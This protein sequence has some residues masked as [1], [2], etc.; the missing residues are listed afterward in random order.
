MTGLTLPKGLGTRH[1]AAAAITEVT[2]ALAVVVSQSN[3]TVRLFQNGEVILRIAPMRHAR[4]MKWQDAETEPALPSLAPTEN[5]TKTETRT[6]IRDR[7]KEKPAL[8]EGCR[9]AASGS[10][11]DFLNT[12]AQVLSMPVVF[13]ASGR[14]ALPLHVR[15]A[16]GRSPPFLSLAYPAARP[17]DDP[18]RDERRRGLVLV[19]DGV[20]GL[21]LC[22]TALRYVLGAEGLPYAVPR[23]SLGAR[24]R[25]LVRRPDERDQPRRQG[26][27]AGRRGAA[28]SAPASR[29]I[30][31]SWS[32]SRG[33]RA[34]WSRR[35]SSSTKTR[36]SRA[37]L[38]APALSPGYDL[39]AA[40]RAVRRE[41]VVFWSP[42]DVI[43]LGAGTR[44]FGTVDRVKTVGAG[45][46]GFRRPPRPTRRRGRQRRRRRQYAKLRQVRW[47]PRMA[48]TGYLGGHVGPDSPVFLRKYVVPLLRA[49]P[50]G[51][52]LN[53]GPGSSRS[54]RGPISIWPGSVGRREG[55][56]AGL[57]ASSRRDETGR[58]R[59]EV[60][61]VLKDRA[62]LIVTRRTSSVRNAAQ[63]GRQRP[64][65]GP[66]SGRLARSR[67]TVTARGPRPRT[68]IGALENWLP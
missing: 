68:A 66:R 30:R 11:P 52:V 61:Q 15:P 10:I 1:W 12:I 47:A 6:R 48:A 43:V 57:R 63:A 33:A 9:V 49:G 25:P 50:D 5:G 13:Q 60:L 64:A 35:S 2:K 36:S 22:G 56:L 67:E 26:R 46:V 24:L 7:D 39:T 44:V 28:V 27:P 21:D 23:L 32:P 59:S 37:V 3:G 45:M 41:M 19:A 16:A 29:T 20:G 65:A 14:T 8:A 42:L 51:R 38:L 34:S 58:A 40:L 62:S 31:S 17:T 53:R 4:A 18:E 55:E 54:R